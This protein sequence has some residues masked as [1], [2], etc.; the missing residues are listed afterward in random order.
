MAYAGRGRLAHAVSEA[1]GLGMLGVGSRD[2]VDY[3]EKQAAVARGEGTAAKFGIG[4]MAWALETRP[5]LLQAA[6]AQQP[7][8]LSISFG[9]IRP[10]VE[11]AHRAGILVATQVSTRRA[12]VAAAEAGADLIVAQGTEA[13]GHTGSVGTLP[14][15]QLVLDSVN[16][17]VAAAG[18]IASAAG[19]A[20]VLAAGAAAAWIGT[21]LLLSP[22]ADVTDEARG[23]LAEADETQTIHTTVFDRVNQI[24]W[25]PQFPGRA[26]RNHFA[27][28]WDGREEELVSNAEE[29]AAFRRGAEAKD[30]D[31]T[32]I[33]AGQSVGMLF[34]RLPAG[35]V[36]RH[37]GDGAERLLR[38][39]MQTL[40]DAH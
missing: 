19:V 38:R 24:P 7:F 26:L 23:R 12:A 21:A 34:E 32:S 4:L 20:A 11:K 5:E 27:D 1:G 15:L 18:G 30:Y 40:F 33:Y 16:V 3:L 31:I 9:S 36:V 28:Q 17:P 14:L 37:L 29:I 25:P 2:S 35:D 10:Y 13:G 6:I 39:R 22:E 8:L